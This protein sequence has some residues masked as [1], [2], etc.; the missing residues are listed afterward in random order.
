MCALIDKALAVKIGVSLKLRTVT[1]QRTWRRL[2]DLT[3]ARRTGTLKV[4][5]HGDFL[6]RH[7]FGCMHIVFAWLRSLWLAMVVICSYQCDVIFIDQVRASFACCAAVVDSLLVDFSVDTIVQVVQASARVV[8]LPLS[9]QIVVGA[10][11]A[12]EER[13]SSAHRLAGGNNDRWLA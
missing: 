5:V 2:V 6:P 11:F 4:L 9:R 1:L 10:R 12:S 13:V 3:H 8:L 7:V